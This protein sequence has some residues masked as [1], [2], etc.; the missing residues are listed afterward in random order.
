MVLYLYT[1]FVLISKSYELLHWF[2]FALDHYNFSLYFMLLDNSTLKSF[3]PLGTKYHTTNMHMDKDKTACACRVLSI[4]C[5]ILH[6]EIKTDIKISNAPIVSIIEL[7]FFKNLFQ[8][9]HP[10]SY[11]TK[12]NHETIQIWYICW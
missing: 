10:M 5:I 12:R 9:I 11:A 8:N 2:V 3:H 6:L 4:C 7:A 1:L